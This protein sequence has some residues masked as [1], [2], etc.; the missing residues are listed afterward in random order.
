MRRHDAHTKRFC[1][2]ESLEDRMTPT[3]L[4]PVLPSG[5][6]AGTAIA[7][8][9]NGNS[10]A[11]VRSPIFNGGTINPTAASAVSLPSAAGKGIDTATNHN[12]NSQA[13]V[14]SPVFN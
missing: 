12:G 4:A 5:G 1:R 2:F 14:H 3:P 13:S 6:V 9:H 8:S 10:Q 7:A 11:I